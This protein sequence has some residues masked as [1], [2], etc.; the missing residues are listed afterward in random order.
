MQLNQAK[1]KQAAAKMCVGK[2][3]YS[4]QKALLRAN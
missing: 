1:N 3:H 4:L 2:L